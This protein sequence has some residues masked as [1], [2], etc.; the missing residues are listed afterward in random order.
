MTEGIIVAV[1]VGGLSFMGVIVSS[2]QSHNLQEQKQNATIE[3]IRAE[4]KNS[5]E[6]MKTEFKSNCDSILDK[7]KQLE[8]KQDK[9]NGLMEKVYKAEAHIE[10]LNCKVESLEKRKSA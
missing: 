1:I 7:I 4:Y 9:H 2:K 6:L 8:K 10:T 3:A 5:M